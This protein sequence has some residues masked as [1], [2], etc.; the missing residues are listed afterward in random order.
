MLKLLLKYR[1]IQIVF[2]TIAVTIPCS[3]K[4]ELKQYLGIEINIKTKI[5]DS[6]KS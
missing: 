6:K 2:L 1:H 5:N 3:V 4:K